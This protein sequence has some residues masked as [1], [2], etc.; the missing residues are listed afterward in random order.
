MIPLIATAKAIVPPKKPIATAAMV[1]KMNVSMVNSF[2]VGHTFTAEALSE[3]GRQKCAICGWL[4]N[5]RFLRVAR[6][7]N[8][9]PGYY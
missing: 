8:S 1:K 6:K 4:K 7:R 5:D 3:L 2:C 9:T